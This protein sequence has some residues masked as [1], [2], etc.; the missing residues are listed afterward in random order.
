M[1]T[2]RWSPEVEAQFRSLMS[3]GASALLVS[4]QIG[5]S[6]RMARRL[7][8]RWK[9]GLPLVTRMPP[10][11]ATKP[12]GRYAGRPGRAWASRMADM[13]PEQREPWRQKALARAAEGMSVE[14]ISNSIKAPRAIIAQ[15]IAEVYGADGVVSEPNASADMAEFMPGGYWPRVT[16]SHDDWPADARFEDDPR[17][18]RPEPIWRPVYAVQDRMSYCSNATA[19]CAA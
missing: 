14:R 10:K 6:E 2:Y 12:S 8:L 5:C 11:V 13:T 9:S 4:E 16:A 7:I 17:A 19:W 3:V 18:C 15:W 1:E